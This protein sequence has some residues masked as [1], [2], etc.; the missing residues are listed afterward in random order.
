[1]NATNVIAGVVV[2]GY[3]LYF[4][5]V[6]Y[7]LTSV[8]NITRIYPL[9]ESDI[10]EGKTPVNKFDTH[11]TWIPN[12][13]RNTLPQ[14]EDIRKMLI[15]F[16]PLIIVHLLISNGIQYIWTKSKREGICHYRVY[17]N[18]ILSIAFLYVI[19]GNNILWIAALTLINYALIKFSVRVSSAKGLY[20]L[21]HIC[22]WAYSILLF[23]TVCTPEYEFNWFNAIYKRLFGEEEVAIP[24]MQ[25]LQYILHILKRNQGF[26]SFG[27]F[28]RLCVVRMI[29]YDMDYTWTRDSPTK[30][31]ERIYYSFTNYLFYVLYVPL[32]L[33]GPVCTY[34][35]F[36]AR[37]LKPTETTLDTHPNELYQLYTRSEWW[38]EYAKALIK[39]VVFALLLDAFTHFCYFNN[40]YYS[41]S[42]DNM[43]GLECFIM[44]YVVGFVLFWG[45]YYCLFGFSRLWANLDCV[46]HEKSQ[47]SSEEPMYRFWI[48]S[49]MPLCSWQCTSL[50]RYSLETWHLSLADWA[51]RYL[52]VPLGGT[53]RAY[54][55]ATICFVFSGTIHGITLKML[56]LGVIKLYLPF[57]L[58]AIFRYFCHRFVEKKVDLRY[59][60]WGLVMLTAFWNMTIVAYQFLPSER[61][62]KDM[63]EHTFIKG[64][65]YPF[66]FM[67]IFFVCKVVLN[68]SVEDHWTSNS[69]RSVGEWKLEKKIWTLGDIP[70]YQP[71]FSSIKTA[72]RGLATE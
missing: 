61:S 26:I 23:V 10:K 32:Y 57:I 25:L 44:I 62:A 38:K 4:I 37:W 60:R 59:H 22:C 45:R 50:N 49:D 46:H 33:T 65:L 24:D 27:P 30:N 12:R 48:P 58:E 8:E 13:R 70:E 31:E 7:E 43:T 9:S 72:V 18:L 56:S 51:C 2:A 47:L 3:L 66:L 35:S 36:I 64:G 53:K 19:N 5:S 41:A 67:Y 6:S 55:G 17:F 54:I 39:F 20:Y 40:Y 29:S 69:T 34:H 68:F 14:Y 71:S 52:F 1:M 42:W 63:V 11:G 21:P 15:V 28:Y 16:I